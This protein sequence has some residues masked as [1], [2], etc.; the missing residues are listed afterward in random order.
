MG[1]FEGRFRPQPQPS[2]ARHRPEW[3][4]PPRAVVPGYS[5]QQALLVHT[6]S[7]FLVAHRF[8]AYP[9]GL[10]FDLLF[11]SREPTRIQHFPWELETP[12]RQ[13]VEE[14]PDDLLL[15]GVELADGSAWSNLDP[16]PDGWGPPDP[17]HVARQGGGGGDGK[18]RQSLWLWPLPPGDVMAFIV[19][20]PSEG[21]KETRA[22]VDAAELRERAAEAQVLWADG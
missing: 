14:I 18:W 19:E 4:E 6:D 10:T 11:Q 1:F 22:D 13:D 15:I 17:P 12:F 9:T 20:W 21:V 7:L 2:E 16:W 3:S 8:A 5:Q